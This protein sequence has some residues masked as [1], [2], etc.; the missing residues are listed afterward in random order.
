M[1][2]ALPWPGSARISGLR[3]SSGGASASLYLHRLAQEAAEREVGPC[4]LAADVIAQWWGDGRRQAAAATAR[5]GGGSGHLPSAAEQA[6]GQGS[7]AVL[8][9]S[10]TC[11]W[12]L[13]RAP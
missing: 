9:G 10:L 12:C 1:S 7:A 6:G 2:G 4:L 5:A 11:P 8:L 3:F 13:G